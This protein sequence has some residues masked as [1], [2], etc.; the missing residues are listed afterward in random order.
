MWFLLAYLICMIISVEIFCP[1]YKKFG[2]TSLYEYLEKRYDRSLRKA[3]EGALEK[4]IKILFLNIY[5]WA[6]L[7]Y[8][9]TLVYI[10][11]NIIYN[12]MVIYMPAVA[13]ETVTGLSK[14]AAVWLI[15]GIC[16]FYTSLGKVFIIVKVIQSLH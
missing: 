13:L 8:F 16:V 9:A 5:F 2:L 14:W 11:Q 12:G 4:N 3:F 6:S 15:G 7:R 1:M 10:V